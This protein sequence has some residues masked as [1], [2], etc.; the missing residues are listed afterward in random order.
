MKNVSHGVEKIENG[1]TYDL[2]DPLAHL[3]RQPRMDH[4]GYYLSGAASE[5][6]VA[7][8]K[9]IDD[10]MRDIKPDQTITEYLASK[11]R[12]ELELAMNTGMPVW[13]ERQPSSSNVL[14]KFGKMLV[15]K[16]TT[17]PTD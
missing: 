12:R 4:P 8:L 15:N 5:Y 3:S 11:D 13:V 6:T 16:F 10:L 9:P 1:V 2:V 7:L 14:Q 17:K